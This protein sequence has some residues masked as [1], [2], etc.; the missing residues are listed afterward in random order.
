VN[1]LGSEL[2]VNTFDQNNQIHP[3]AVTGAAFGFIVVWDSVGAQDGSAIGIFAQRFAS[4]GTPLATEF[5]VNTFTSNPQRRPRMASDSSG[6]F[7]VVWQSSGQDG[8]EYG[9]FAQRFT[10]AGTPLAAEFQVNTYTRY[11][12]IYPAVAVDGDGD[13]VVIWQSNTEDGDNYG[14]FAR[15]FSSAGAPLAT[16]F[17]VNTY[18]TAAQRY[19]SIA[20]DA[21]GDF[22]VAWQSFGQDGSD[23]AVIAQRFSSTGAFLATEFQVGLYTQDGQRDPSVD[24]DVAGNF[25]IVWESG[26]DGSLYGISARQFTRGGAPR[27]REIQINTYTLGQQI[28][29]TVE[30]DVVGNFVVAWESYFQDGSLGGVFAQR[31]DA[32]AVLDADGVGT[33]SALTDGLLLVRFLFGFTGASLTSGATGGSCTQCGAASLEQY[34]AGLGLTLDIDGNGSLGAL[35]DGLLILRYLFGFTGD[36]LT[37]GAVGGGCVR[38]DAATIVPYLAGLQI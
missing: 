10:S 18:T 19:P 22:V 37:T 32:L 33:L 3:A 27:S 26:L 25:V 24:S 9:I 12:Q 38:C 35:T 28:A 17:Q 5:Q 29:P 2:Q 8:S 23:Y 30:L 6:G 16:E 1:P 4:T 7:V 36:T 21:H 31:F 15:R 20:E 11:T 13:F 34:F 14:I